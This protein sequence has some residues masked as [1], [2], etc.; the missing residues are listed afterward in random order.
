VPAES[1]IDIIVRWPAATVDGL[2]QQASEI[3]AA[4]TIADAK[5]IKSLDPSK[6]NATVPPLPVSETVPMPPL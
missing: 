5:F 6:E 4:V 1:V 3:G 2:I